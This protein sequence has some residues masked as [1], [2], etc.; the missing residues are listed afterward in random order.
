MNELP[1]TTGGR[2]CELSLSSTIAL[3][4]FRFPD[5]RPVV[6]MVFEGRISVIY[7]RRGK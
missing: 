5:P 6:G 3:F 7:T 2:A 1:V 4:L